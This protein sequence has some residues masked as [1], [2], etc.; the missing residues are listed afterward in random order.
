MRS[1]KSQAS[2]GLG[3]QSDQ[4]RQRLL[5]RGNS[6]QRTPLRG[7]PKVYDADDENFIGTQGKGTYAGVNI[8]MQNDISYQ[9]KMVERRDIG[10]IS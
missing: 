3:D 8:N 7:R 9:T 5:S 1:Y 4:K 6:P 10:E 2:L